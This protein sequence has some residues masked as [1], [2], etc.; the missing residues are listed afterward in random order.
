MLGGNGLQWDG[1]GRG[2]REGEGGV[3]EKKAVNRGVGE[4]VQMER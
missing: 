4:A 2:G 3:A 1:R